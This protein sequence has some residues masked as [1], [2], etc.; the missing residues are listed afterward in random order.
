MAGKSESQKTISFRLNMAREEE[1]ELYEVIIAHNRGKANDT[2]GSSG[3]Y[4]K[5][6]M[7]SFHS[8]ETQIEEH[9]KSYLE[10]QKFSIQQAEIQKELFL[11]ALDTHYQKLACML[12]ESITKAMCSQDHQSTSGEAV[13]SERDFKNKEEKN[14]SPD[15]EDSMPEEAFSYLQNL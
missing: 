5:A 7:R 8:N 3:A 15:M 6:A 9:K 12:V 14:T 13:R 10:M 2:Y 4:I 1:K 11:E